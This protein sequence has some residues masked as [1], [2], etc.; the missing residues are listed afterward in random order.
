MNTEPNGALLEINRATIYHEARGRGSSVLFIAGATGDGGHFQRVAE[1]LSDEFTVVTYDRRR[2]LRGASGF[3]NDT[4]DY[5][6][7]KGG[8]GR[9]ELASE[10]LE[11]EALGL[12]E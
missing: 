3:L 5:D 2:E 7:T 12:G 4:V 9:H 6:I 11:K 8:C 10:L 1:L